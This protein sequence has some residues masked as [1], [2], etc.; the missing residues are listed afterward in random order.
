MSQCF[1]H[2]TDIVVLCLECEQLLCFK[3]LLAHDKTHE[4]KMVEY[5][6][7]LGF[8]FELNQKTCKKT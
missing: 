4:N 1:L 3:C 5:K 8:F 7:L 2:K 6:K